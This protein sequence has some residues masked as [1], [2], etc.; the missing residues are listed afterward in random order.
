MERPIS[1]D[2]EDTQEVCLLHRDIKT[3]KA[4]LEMCL[5]TDFEHYV[6]DD[7]IEGGDQTDIKPSVFDDNY[8]PVKLEP[9]MYNAEESTSLIIGKLL[10]QPDHIAK[11]IKQDLIDDVAHRIADRHMDSCEISQYIQE[12]DKTIGLCIEDVRHLLSAEKPPNEDTTSVSTTSLPVVMQ[13]S[14]SEAMSSSYSDTIPY[15]QPDNGSGDSIQTIASS[16]IRSELPV[17]TTETHP[18]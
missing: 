6:R 18:P 7:E 10:L 1:I 2:L 4:Y 13:I 9:D 8:V 11:E 14:P 15:V 16:H 5:D 3:H 12:K 17:V